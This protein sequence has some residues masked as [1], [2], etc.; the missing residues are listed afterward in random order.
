MY[1]TLYQIFDSDRPYI[2]VRQAEAHE[3]AQHL[4]LHPFWRSTV[5]P[6]LPASVS[7]DGNPPPR[8]G[9]LES[10]DRVYLP[11]G[12]PQAVLVGLQSIVDGWVISKGD[13]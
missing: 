11:S 8:D 5:H 1:K 3:L 10:T 12:V 4:F 2:W 6:S 7:M 9:I 13:A